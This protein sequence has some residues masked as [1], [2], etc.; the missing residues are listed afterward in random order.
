[1]GLST[2]KKWPALLLT[3]Y[4]ALAAIGTFTFSMFETLNFDALGEDNP[5]A[6]VFT[7]VEL[8]FDW[9][10]GGQTLIGRAGRRL[11]SSLHG[12]L[13]RILAPETGKAGA[14]LLYASVKT[15]GKIYYPLIK[16]AIPL[17]LRT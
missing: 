7:A 9:L 8:A 5:V 10:A 14:V 6:A 1:M 15:F 17:K 2:A 16:N 12:G 3:A 4:L 11:A 13:P